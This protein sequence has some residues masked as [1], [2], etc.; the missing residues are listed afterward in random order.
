MIKVLPYSDNQTLGV[1]IQNSYGKDEIRFIKAEMDKRILRG[2]AKVNLLLKIDKLKFNQYRPEILF[3]DLRAG[4][5]EYGQIGHIAV[6]GNTAIEEMMVTLDNL[7]FG[8][9]DR[10]LIEKYFDIENLEE[11]W[12]FVKE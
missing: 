2:S 1:E 11:A 9:P 8:D 6:V 4:F 5:K 12:N 3:E 10:N 7:I